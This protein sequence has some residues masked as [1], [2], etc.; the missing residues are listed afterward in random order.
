MQLT[1]S[2]SFFLIFE[3][4]FRGPH[5]AVDTYSDEVHNSVGLEHSMEDQEIVTEVVIIIFLKIITTS[6]LL[7]D[8]SQNLLTKPLFNAAYAF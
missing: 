6:R 7:N 3:S 2:E 1:K 5:S 4:V 8:C